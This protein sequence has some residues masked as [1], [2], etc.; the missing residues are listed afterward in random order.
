MSIALF[1]LFTVQVSKVT[2]VQAAVSL[3]LPP[4]VVLPASVL[5]FTDVS[6]CFGL[7]LHD[8]NHSLSLSSLLSPSPICAVPRLDISKSK[9]E[10]Y[11]VANFVF[12]RFPNT[13]G[14]D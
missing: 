8:V 14:T 13:R 12:H 5:M 11:H 7:Y 9:S 4:S 2:G 1:F 6:S 3:C 10:T